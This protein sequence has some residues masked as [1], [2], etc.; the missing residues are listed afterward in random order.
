MVGFLLSNRP[1]VS[2]L[3]LALAAAPVVFTTPAQATIQNGASPRAATPAGQPRPV[4][5]LEGEIGEGRGRIIARG[6]DGY[7]GEMTIP[8][9]RNPVVVLK[10]SSDFAPHRPAVDHITLEIGAT[11]DATVS[12]RVSGQFGVRTGRTVSVVRTTPPTAQD[13]AW[14]EAMMS[15]AAL[16]ATEGAISTSITYPAGEFEDDYNYLLDLLQLVAGWEVADLCVN[17]PAS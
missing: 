15:G 17:R 10:V 11:D 2:L 5:G 1:F 13:A 7:R 8:L 14:F 12:R 6:P 4:C 3:I 9:A 16:T